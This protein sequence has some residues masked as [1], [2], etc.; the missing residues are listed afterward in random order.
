M[1]DARLLSLIVLFAYGLLLHS[2]I[3]VADEEVRNLLNKAHSRYEE[4]LEEVEREVFAKLDELIDQYADEGRLQK[5]LEL[6]EERMRLLEDRAWPLAIG[7]QS[8]RE[9]VRATRGRARRELASAY[10]NAIAQL[11]KERRYEAAVALRDELDE[12]KKLQSEFD[13]RSA[14]PKRKKGSKA[15]DDRQAKRDV[16]DQLQKA[17]Q[18]QPEPPA[19]PSPSEE[20]EES[21]PAMADVRPPAKPA[22]PAKG[23]E[24][25]P[26]VAGGRPSATP[27]MPAKSEENKPLVTVAP[28]SATPA[29]PAQ[30]GDR[31]LSTKDL[32]AILA[33]G[34]AKTSLDDPL[35]TSDEK[36]KG[37]R[38][39]VEKVYA[40][41]PP[42]LW[43]PRQYDD[44]IEFFV[45]ASVKAQ[46]CQLPAVPPTPGTGTS[47]A[48]DI[49]LGGTPPID[50]VRK[51]AGSWPAVQWLLSSL[52]Q[53][54]FISRAI[55][56]QSKEHWPDINSNTKAD[57]LKMWL[58]S[59]GCTDVESCRAFLRKTK[60]AGVRLTVL[61]Q[62]RTE[63]GE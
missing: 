25:E 23:S 40:D 51:C 2:P 38:Q 35:A 32:A 15:S 5:V 60:E 39:L 6:R 45:A 16:P 43:T 47:I 34:A 8:T 22:M 13:F 10:E 1:T 14:E 37:L 31:E 33:E 61:D 46:T 42:R 41:L 9:K 28:P 63:F 11:T 7:F 62:L 58:K 57:Q 19:S 55:H 12:L 29:M 48:G 18:Q 3:A 59:T 36:G 30:N 53:S 50:L 27:A 52:T 17:P 44:F 21:E 20:S 26:A 49:G 4:Q 56:L 24:S 54:D